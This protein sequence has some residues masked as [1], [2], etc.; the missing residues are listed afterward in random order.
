M[1]SS[2][3]QVSRRL[4]LYLRRVTDGMWTWLGGGHLIGPKV[5]GTGDHDCALASL[6]WTAPWIPET[7]IVEALQFCT[8]TW[9][10]G[11]ITNKELQIALA[12][13]NVK[14]H[15]SSEKTT[16]GSLLAAR[17]RKCIALVPH[18]FIAIVNGRIV[19]R[20]ALIDWDPCTTVYCHWILDSRRFRSGACK[21]RIDGGNTESRSPRT[22]GG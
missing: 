17:P 22:G 4:L 6:Y 3:L 20:D 10:Y 9:P 12:Y 16:L 19:G 21:H 1:E 14:A 8:N 18:H 2:G 5:V 11:G 7:Q 15:Y 13:L